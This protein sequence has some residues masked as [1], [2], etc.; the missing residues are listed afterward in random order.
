MSV[1]NEKDILCTNPQFVVFEI[2][3]N[4]NCMLLLFMNI[5]VSLVVI[6]HMFMW[7]AQEVFCMCNL[8]R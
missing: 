5:K 2:V 1:G 4:P 7:E 8:G 3:W 6:D